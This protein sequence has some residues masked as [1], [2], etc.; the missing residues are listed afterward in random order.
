MTAL[1]GSWCDDIHK[2][3]LDPINCFCNVG[4]EL[5]V[6]SLPVLHLFLLILLILSFSGQGNLGE[7]REYVTSVHPG[8]SLYGRL[9]D[10]AAEL[11]WVSLS[12]LQVLAF[13]FVLFVLS[14]F[15]HIAGTKQS[16]WQNLSLL[17][18]LNL[19]NLRFDTW[20]LQWLFLGCAGCT[21]LRD[22]FL[23]LAKGKERKSMLKLGDW[24]NS[25][26]FDVS[27]ALG[28]P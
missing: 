7:L 26:C 25:F 28:S 17:S 23:L 3:P 5:T 19:G 13:C 11:L 6:V 18:S 1:L 12:V 14:C 20:H 4:Q 10:R 27:V 16:V 21:S 9:G 8:C 15:F 2:N 22:E 24:W